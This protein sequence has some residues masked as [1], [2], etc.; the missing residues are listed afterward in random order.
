M[1]VKELK[2]KTI[3]ELCSLYKKL[4]TEESD[5]IDQYRLTLKEIDRMEKELRELKKEERGFQDFGYLKRE[6]TTVLEVI[7]EAILLGNDFK[8]TTEGEK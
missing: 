6:S 5:I 1:D 7:G 2:G 8:I 4:A 3:E